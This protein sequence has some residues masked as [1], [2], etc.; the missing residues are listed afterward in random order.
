M[1]LN[2]SLYCLTWYNVTIG[3]GDLVPQKDPDTHRHAQDNLKV[4]LLPIGERPGSLLLTPT[5]LTPASPT[6][7]S[8][9]LSPGVRVTSTPPSVTFNARYISGL[10]TPMKSP[11][12][13]DGK[14]LPISRLTRQRS[15][16]SPAA[17]K[18]IREPK[19]ISHFNITIGSDHGSPQNTPST[20]SGH[21]TFPETPYT[22]ALWSSSTAGGSP[23]A[24]V[25]PT[26]SPTFIP[27][28]SKSASL[29][30]P[31]QGSRPNLTQ[32]VLLFRATTVAGN[33]SLTD[34]SKLQTVA[35]V[36]EARPASTVP[37]HSQSPSSLNRPPSGKL[38]SDRG[39]TAAPVRLL[40]PMPS[41]TPISQL[42]PH[43]QVQ[44]AESHPSA[45]ETEPRPLPNIS[46]TSPRSSLS[47]HSLSPTARSRSP[48]HTSSPF[49]SACGPL[50][51]QPS[52]QRDSLLP[53][54]VSASG[55]TVLTTN[56][57]TK[58]PSLDSRPAPTETQTSTPPESRHLSEADTVPYSHPFIAPPPYQAVVNNY[59][60]T[61]LVSRQGSNQRD[62]GGASTVLHIPNINHPAPAGQSSI[63]R[64]TRPRP[65]L[66]M[67]PR[68]PVPSPKIPATLA[69]PEHN[70]SVS[71]TS[72]MDGAGG[73]ISSGGWR[74][75][76]AQCPSP[77]FQIPAPKFRGYTL[78][79]AQWTFTSEQLQAIVS[80]AIKQSAEASSVRLLRL[81]T[82]DTDIPA[83]MHRLEMQKTDLK[84]RYKHLTR[85]RWTLL[86]NLATHL[87]GF[88]EA[89]SI[90][91]IRILEDLADVSL[92]LDQHT[93]ELDSVTEQLAQLRSIGDVHS[94]S[95]LAMAL[96]KLNTSFLKQVTENQTLREQLNTLE[97]E[98]DEAWKQAEDVAQEYDDLNDRYGEPS[99]FKALNNKR[100]SHV[101]AVR[102]SSM[103]VSR[104]GLRSASLRRSQ[105]SSAASSGYRGSMTVP[106]SSAGDVPPVPPIPHQTTLGV[107]TA[108]LPS[109]NSL[110]AWSFHYYLSRSFAFIYCVDS[111][112]IIFSSV[113]I[114][115]YAQS[116]RRTV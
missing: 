2:A 44:N 9:P 104:A 28:H 112:F 71:S 36:A 99:S 8:L 74:K 108:D 78:E 87:E 51:D 46:Q 49:L 17:L 101:S 89:D 93:E 83:E 96:R 98:R 11:D 50:P 5:L 15:G 110:G 43:I 59:L 85:K 30:G 48:S 22:A 67:G 66:P 63:V 31:M 65:P 26:S 4:K 55:A 76:V 68:K 114:N 62:N 116:P 42:G 90:F 18:L 38:L 72:T 33:R 82:L 53:P 81:E 19:D 10:D 7:G 35:E 107:L 13:L 24:T 115:R 80:R 79:A 20:G 95:A 37:S 47:G 40:P 106:L 1:L 91:T 61:P 75:L 54:G 69:L 105:R 113:G 100:S 32:Q 45:A 16:S 12:I 103:L 21:Q 70:A 27:G 39:D 97:A 111:H 25:S 94:A 3:R 52:I 41:T 60:P 6:S 58:L 102:K 64:A 77:K 57:L 56:D 86:G 84:G 109:H 34:T 73:S 14:L 92:M 88:G 23:G 29:S